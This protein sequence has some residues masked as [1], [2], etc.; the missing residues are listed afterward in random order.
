MHTVQR[1]SASTIS[2]LWCWRWDP[3]VKAATYHVGF[4]SF[5]FGCYRRKRCSLSTEFQTFCELIVS[6]ARSKPRLRLFRPGP[7]KAAIGFWT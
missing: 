5:C 6:A 4:S 1:L 2:A 7:G 3:S